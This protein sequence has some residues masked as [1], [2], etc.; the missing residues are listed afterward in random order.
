MCRSTLG[1]DVRE[2]V[3]VL[4]VTRSA[5]KNGGRRTSHVAGRGLSTS[6]LLQALLRFSI[7]RNVLTKKDTK[8]GTES[9]APKR[10]DEL[11]PIFVNRGFTRHLERWPLASFVNLFPTF[12]P[13]SSERGTICNCRKAEIFAIHGRYEFTKTATPNREFLVKASNIKKIN[14]LYFDDDVIQNTLFIVRF[15][16][17][18]LMSCCDKFARVAI[19][20]F[21]FLI[22]L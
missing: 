2:R 17:E 21:K 15:S 3:R 13:P 9:Y 10:R 12:Q 18:L 20:F 1:R 11:I 19:M 4:C 8:E 7:T 14:T 16:N 6:S 22:F 5:V